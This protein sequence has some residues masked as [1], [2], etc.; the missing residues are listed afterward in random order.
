M[1]TAFLSACRL[2]TPQQEADLRPC[3]DPVHQHLRLG[4]DNHTPAVEDSWRTDGQDRAACD[5]VPGLPRGA[6][7]G[8]SVLFRIALASLCSRQDETDVTGQGHG[9]KMSWWCRREISA[10]GFSPL[11]P[12]SVGYVGAWLCCS[13]F[14][15]HGCFA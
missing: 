5:C 3:F 8:S 13:T 2:Q 7:R 12:S 10:C 1:V 6:C 9:S 4:P 14:C 15:A 11:V